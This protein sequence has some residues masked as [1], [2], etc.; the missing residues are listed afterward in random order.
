MSFCVVI[1]LNKTTRTKLSEL[2]VSRKCNEIL[3][4]F[5]LLALNSKTTVFIT[6]FNKTLVKLHYLELL[7]EFVASR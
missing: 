4:G 3:W 5:F 7:P 1:S 2:L 6:D